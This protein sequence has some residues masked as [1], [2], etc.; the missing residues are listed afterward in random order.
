ML[1]WLPA[2]VDYRALPW[3]TFTDPELAQAGLT[4]AQARERHGEVRLARWSFHEND[5]AQA[6]RATAGAVK[7]V[8]DRRGRVLGAGIAG[9]RAGEL[10]QPWVLAI[11]KRLTLR[12]MAGTIAPYPTLGEAGKRA[13]GG[14]F[15]PTLF[16][17]R[18]RRLVRFLARFG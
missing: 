14:F 18:T 15:A 9:A 10:I 7:I 17:D 8:A 13:A 5:R 3:V 11:Q 6:E 16:S 4:E 1:F 2:K 12:D